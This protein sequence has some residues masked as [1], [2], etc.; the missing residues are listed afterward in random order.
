M[1]SLPNRKNKLLKKIPQPKARPSP[2][3][4]SAH[5]AFLSYLLVSQLSNIIMMMLVMAMMMM[6]IK[7]MVMLLAVMVRMM[8]MVIM[9]MVKPLQLSLLVS[10]I[11][12]LS[13]SSPLSRLSVRLF[14]TLCTAACITHFDCGI[15]LLL[16]IFALISRASLIHC[17]RKTLV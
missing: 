11:S 8:V 9:E 16:D 14:Y 6:V 15:V 3:L 7:L 10:L 4:F 12:Q 2:L 1:I 13:A 5:F 17:V